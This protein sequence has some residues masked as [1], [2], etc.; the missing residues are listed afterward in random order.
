M[1]L[2]RYA[3]LF[4]A[5]GYENLDFVKSITDKE[6]LTEIGIKKKGHLQR[7]MVEIEK[8]RDRDENHNPEGSQIN[9]NVLLTDSVRNA[10]E[11]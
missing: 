9:L 6:N 4:H 8:L 11:Q 1:G 5:E 10:F 3:K 2:S 7:L